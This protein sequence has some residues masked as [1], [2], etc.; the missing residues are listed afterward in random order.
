MEKVSKNCIKG[1]LITSAND[2]NRLALEKRSI[3]TKNWGVKPAA[4]LLGMPFRIVIDLIDRKM[5]FTAIKN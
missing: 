4:I 2:I 5:L 1:E 3:Y